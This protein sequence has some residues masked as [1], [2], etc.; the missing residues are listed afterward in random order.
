[1]DKDKDKN[2]KPC[3]CKD[4]YFTNT[5]GPAVVKCQ[6]CGGNQKV[7]RFGEGEKK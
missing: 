6:V 3:T 5:A 7:N 1:M 2:S 4:G